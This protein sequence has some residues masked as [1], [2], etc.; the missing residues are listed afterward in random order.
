MLLKMPQLWTAHCVSSIRSFRVLMAAL[1]LAA[2]DS[3]LTKCTG[4]GGLGAALT[5]LEGLLSDLR[6]QDLVD[7]LR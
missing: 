3:V 5:A 2:L 6:V 7:F 1:A 4:D